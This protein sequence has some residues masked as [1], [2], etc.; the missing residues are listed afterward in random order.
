LGRIFHAKLSAAEGGLMANLDFRFPMY[1]WLKRRGWSVDDLTVKRMT[2]IF[3]RVQAHLVETNVVEKLRCNVTIEQGGVMFPK[4]SAALSADCLRLLHAPAPLGKSVRGRGGSR[5]AAGG[6]VGSDGGMSVSALGADDGTEEDED[7]DDGGS[8]GDGDGDGE[9]AARESAKLIARGGG[10]LV[11]E[12]RMEDQIV[13]LVK[14]AGP[15]GLRVPDLAK[16]FNLPTKTF[17]QRIDIMVTHRHLFGIS[18]QVKQE[19]KYRITSLWYVGK[20][21]V[22]GNGKPTAAAEGPEDKISPSGVKRAARGALLRAH[23]SQRGYAVKAFM[24]REMRVEP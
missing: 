10:L 4:S 21:T 20:P 7:E 9:A 6:G 14:A 17:K 3:A 13:D 1:E 2:K 22:A 19:G 23:V 12:T 8:D 16:R 15:T 5:A 24:G 11:M 18:F